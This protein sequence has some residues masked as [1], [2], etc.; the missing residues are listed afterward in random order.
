MR[1][2]I[3]CNIYILS[4]TAV[5]SAAR[6]SRPAEALMNPCEAV[7]QA[8]I[9][10]PEPL[11]SEGV[12]YGG[13]KK[14]RTVKERYRYGGDIRVGDVNDDGTVDFVVFKSVDG[15]KP[16]FI[17]AF[18]WGGK[19]LWQWGDKQRQV[20]HHRNDRHI[21]P[22]ESPDRP[23]PVLVVDIDGD[24]RTEVVALVLKEGVSATDVWKTADMEFVVLD[25]VTGKVE[26][27]A[28]PDALKAAGAMGNDGKD[29]VPNYVHQRLMAADFRGTGGPHDFVI[30]L[31]NSIIACSDKLEVLWTYHNKFDVY[32]R[33]SSYIPCVGDIDYD[34][35]DEVLGGNFLLDDNGSVMWEK[36]MAEH[37]DSVA[38]AEWDGDKSNGREALLSGWGQVVNVRDDV[39]MKL[40]PEVVPHGQ[41]LRVGRFRQD[42]PGLQLAIR[43][44]G[45]RPKILYVDRAGEVLERFEV[46]HSP[47]EVGMAMVH[48]YGPDQPDLL[49]SPTSLYDGYGRKAVRLPGIAKASRRGRMGWFH[50]I[51]ADLEGMGRESV[52]LY[53]AHADEVFV[54]GEN[55]LQ[56]DPP[57][58]YRHTARQYNVRLMD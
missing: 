10:I 6:D 12:V 7:L 5:M 44:N 52:I 33:H 15:L 38:I 37:N 54:Y 1:T 40:G 34:G 58:G 17:A 43:Y 23:G 25:G 4:L 49:Y 51:P 29:K 27:R 42:R 20:R 22:I 41:E 13:D 56:N 28:A 50:C 9:K 3:Y 19:V 14:N 18:D 47:I 2:I 11:L 16:C 32:G 31:G 48:W 8:R 53:D 35:R 36:M 55:E 57:V 26:R 39:L 46:D 24:G 21:F 45:H 30:K